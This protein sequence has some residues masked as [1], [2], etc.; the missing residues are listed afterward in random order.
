M[1]YVSDELPNFTCAAAS[2]ASPSRDL[3]PACVGP[4]SVLHEDRY[5]INAS[6]V[7]TIKWNICG[8]LRFSDKQIAVRSQSLVISPRVGKIRRDMVT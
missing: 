1:H 2:S 3:S 4:S 8:A 5:L 6:S 7:Q